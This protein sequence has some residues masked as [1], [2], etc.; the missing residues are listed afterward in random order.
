VLFCSRYRPRTV[1][2]CCRYSTSVLAIKTLFVL[3]AIFRG[4]TGSHQEPV[5][6][7]PVCVT[8]PH[9]GPHVSSV[10]AFTPA[11]VAYAL[12]GCKLGPYLTSLTMFNDLHFQSQYLYPI[13][14]VRW[15]LGRSIFRNCSANVGS[16]TLAIALRAQKGLLSSESPSKEDK[17][18][19]GE[20][21]VDSLLLIVSPF[22][23]FVP[24]RLH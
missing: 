4:L 18:S 14:L 20:A 5:E 13:I 11:V 10:T 6:R 7:T 8:I 9:G 24:S 17:L 19:K 3:V 12:E 22:L 15:A 1:Y 16:L 23:H 21:T 2:I